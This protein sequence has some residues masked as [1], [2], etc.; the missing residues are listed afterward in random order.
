MSEKFRRLSEETLHEGYIFNY[1]RA[2]FEDPEGGS[3]ER[4][5]IRHAGAVAALPVEGDQ[6]LLVRQYRPSLDR[7]LLELPAGLREPGEALEVT[8]A[9]ELEE[10]IGRRPGHLELLVSCHTAVGFTDEV[11]TIFVAT[12]LEE[13]DRRADSVEE[14]FMEIVPVAISDI[15]ALVASGDLTD[16]KTIIGLLLYQQQF[17]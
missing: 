15:P 6:I 7:L 11:I 1:N 16:A 17:T 13:V 9:R 2:T 5:V 4:D 10:E 3:F 8:A 14:R 12:D